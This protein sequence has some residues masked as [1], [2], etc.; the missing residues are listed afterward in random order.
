MALQNQQQ[1]AEAAA[2]FRSGEVFSLLEAFTEPVH[3]FF[4]AVLVMAP[5]EGVRR[6]RLL[7]LAAVDALYRYVGDFSRLVV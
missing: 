5:E 2:G 7:L 3:R 6:N 1:I 4:D